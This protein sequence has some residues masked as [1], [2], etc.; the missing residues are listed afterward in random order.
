VLNWQLKRPV[1]SQYDI[2][3]PILA[4]FPP[5]GRI[6]MVGDS[7]TEI[8]EWSGIFPDE[9]IANYGIS[10]DTVDG[11]LARVPSILQGNPEKVFV[12]IGIN[13]LRRGHSV[14]SIIP[15]YRNLVQAL[16]LGSAHVFVQS[17]LCTS[18][19]IYVNPR[20]LELNA[21]LS[22]FCGVNPS[23]CDF[24]GIASSICA[25]DQLDDSMTVDG[26]HLSPL[27]YE[28]RRNARMPLPNMCVA[29]SPTRE[30]TGVSSLKFAVMEPAIRDG[31]LVA[32]SASQ[33]QSRKLQ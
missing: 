2:R 17:T 19:D 21:K 28:R 15:R 13:D 6:A 12:M 23:Q 7:L 27:G 14:S 3:A 4:A 20:V 1:L 10:G 9:T 30:S 11:V 32:H 16:G 26:V 29:N 33:C 25:N 5:K 18:R 31:Q 22:I 8:A 24:I